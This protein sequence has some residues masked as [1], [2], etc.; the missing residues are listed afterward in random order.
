MYIKKSRAFIKGKT[1]EYLRLVQGIRVGSKVKHKV[2]AYLGRSDDPAS[3]ASFLFHKSPLSSNKQQARL[4]GLPMACNFV[5]EKILDL[6]SIFTAVFPAS[7]PKDLFL[8][9]KLM[10]LS[11]IINPDS[12]L[13]LTRWYHHLYLPEKLPKTIDVHKFYG[14]LDYLI[15]KKE[16]IEQELYKKLVK[17]ELIDITLVFYDLTSSYFEGEDCDIAK[18][19]HSRDHRTDCLQI[20]LGLVIDKTGLPI[21]HEV[22]EG[23]MSDSKTVKG[24]LQKV[25]N[26]LSIKNIIFV[27]DK[28]MLSPENVAELENLAKDGYTYIISQSPRTGYEDFKTYLLQKD[29]WIM[30]SN[31]LYF[32]QTKDIQTKDT[33]T[34]SGLILCCNPKTA[35][36]A[37]YTRDEK[38][39]KL[40]SFIATELS[41]ETLFKR[42]QSKNTIHDRIIKKLHSSH[43]S[44]YFDSKDNFKLKEEILAK[45]ELLDGVWVLTG[46]A[47]LTP[48]EMVKTYKQEA[49]I[50][51]SFRVI[52]NVVEIR[53]IYHYS[54]ARVRAHVFICVLAYLAARILER[55]TG[56]TIKMLKEK[57]MTSVIIDGDTPTS[58]KQIIGKTIDFTS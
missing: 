12:K 13:S 16:P 9:I 8:L 37:K 48:V 6:S 42:K 33:T 20:T 32:T 4:Y 39:D 50:E 43:A 55:K 51:S 3:A 23:N 21:F 14:A 1:Y 34:N 57:Y 30:L 5:M 10:I 58:S 28:G 26:V 49:E 56:Q 41:K 7:V 29:K 24:I 45:E 27:A 25:K 52:K 31:T 54:Q 53:P 44:K 46:N 18:F 35:L 17:E 15:E 36:K 47:N 2:I 19:G 22:F 11:R 38:I 40:T